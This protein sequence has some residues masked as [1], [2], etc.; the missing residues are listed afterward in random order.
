MAN[1]SNFRFPCLRSGVGRQGDQV[2]R[3]VVHEQENTHWH[4]PLHLNF[5][6]ETMPDWFGL[7]DKKDLPATFSIDYVRSWR[8]KPVGA[9]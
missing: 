2:V 9:K 5:D 8:K 4:Q 3:K 7:P 1:K 6:S